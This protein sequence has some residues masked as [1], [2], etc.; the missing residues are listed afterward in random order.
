MT[1]QKAW[2]AGAGFSA[3]VVAASSYLLF[4][5]DSGDRPD[6]VVV[7]VER[8]DVEQLVTATGTLEPIAYVDVGA[9]VSGQLKR[10]PKR[11]G[12]AVKIGEVIA[13]IDDTLAKSRRV[14][15]RATLDNLRAQ[16]AA[17]EAELRFLEQRMARYQSLLEQDAIAREEV[18]IAVS[19]RDA[20]LARLDA[21]AAQI[22]QAEASV[23][24]AETNLSYTIIRAP[25]S[26]V[27]AALYAREGQMLNANQTAPLVLQLADLS[28][29]TVVAQVSEADVFGLEPG[30][31]VY[32][33]VLGQPDQRREGRLRQIK[34][35]PEIVSN[36]VFYHALFDVPNDGSLMSKMTAQVFFVL[37]RAKNARAPGTWKPG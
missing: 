25:I 21:Q 20:A 37:G 32:F 6:P 3:L 33:T 14:E 35:A 4:V 27:V 11:E 12:D 26:G 29:M 10:L 19:N 8:G 15:A 17:Q 13:E 30:Q 24:T 16:R 36:V 5:N 18:E 23:A 1:R 7:P 34:P 22:R 31:P 9:Q 28:A 2:M